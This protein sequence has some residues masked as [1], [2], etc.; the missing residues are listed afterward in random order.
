MS[1]IQFPPQLTRTQAADFLAGQGFPISRRYFEKLCTPGL[2]QGPRVNGW[3][4]PRALYLQG[5]LL[6]W[7]R[8]RCK[9][10]DASKSHAA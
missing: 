7:A 4:G 5:D 10:G 3:F 8:S 1:D 6:E 9:P 2:N